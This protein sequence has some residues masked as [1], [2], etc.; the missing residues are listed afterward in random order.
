MDM[1]EKEIYWQ[2]TELGRSSW[3]LKLAITS[4]TSLPAGISVRASILCDTIDNGYLKMHIPTG[5]VLQKYMMRVLTVSDISNRTW[6][7]F[8]TYDIICNIS[9]L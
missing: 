7:H 1:K 9:E 8:E 4:C 6:W 5:R 3:K 2:R